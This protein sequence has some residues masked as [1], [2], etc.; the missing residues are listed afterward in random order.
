MAWEV[1]NGSGRRVV[2][3]PRPGVPLFPVTATG[4][5][6]IALVVLDGQLRAVRSRGHVPVKRRSDMPVVPVIRRV[7]VLGQNDL[8]HG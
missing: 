6:G 7:S 5:D 8:V 4:I 3:K 1:H 2:V